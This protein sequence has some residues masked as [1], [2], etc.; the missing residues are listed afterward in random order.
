[1]PLRERMR[2]TDEEIGEIDIHCGMSEADGTEPFTR[3]KYE[4]HL[5]KAQL[6]KVFDEVDRVYNKEDKDL[7]LALAYLHK[8]LSEEVEYG[9]NPDNSSHYHPNR[10]AR[11]R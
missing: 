6:K 4:H 10:K 2:L 7:R 3:Y 8:A 1:M 5:L 9:T 11:T